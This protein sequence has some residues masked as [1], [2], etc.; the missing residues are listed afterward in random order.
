MPV[1]GAPG[2][3]GDRP[4]VGEHV[5]RVPGWQTNGIT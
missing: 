3:A 5:A 2:G 1:G 4:E